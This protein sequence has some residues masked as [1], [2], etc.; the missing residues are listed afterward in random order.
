MVSLGL[1]PGLGLSGANGAWFANAGLAMADAAD[2]VSRQ[3]AFIADFRGDRHALTSVPAAG[4]AAAAVDA[5]VALQPVSFADLFLFTRGSAAEHI[6]AAGTPQQAPVDVA[7]FDYRNGYRQLLL[8]GPAT[9]LFLNSH[10]PA[11]QTVAVTNAVQYT[12]SCRG[13]GALVLSGAAA[14]TVTQGSPVT[15]TASSTSLTLTVAGSLSRAQLETGAMASSFV[16]TAAAAATR[17][18]DSC[19]LSPVGEALLQRGA[20]T[21]LLKGQGVQ[22]SLGRLVGIGSGEEIM[23][24]TTPQTSVLAGNS[25]PIATVTVPLPSFGICL[26]W[27]AG[28]RSA[29]YNAGAIATD[30][31][32]PVTSGQA[33]LGRNQNGLFAHGRY[34]SLAI[35]PFRAGNGAI[36]AK[37]GAYS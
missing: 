20:A 8:E 17:S 14:G 24:F 18:A 31:T 5:L 28:G 12:V 33:F 23:R 32:V 10:A 7:R 3:P 30:S 6:D 21:I 13:S 25:L 26:G 11:T 16:Q 22:G 29:C 35:W 1:G 37:A 15:F 4:I 34:D 19:R 36:Q 2:G 9:N 27:N